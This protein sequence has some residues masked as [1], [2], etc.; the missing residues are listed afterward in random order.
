MPRPRLSDFCHNWCGRVSIIC[1]AALVSVVT[2]AAAEVVK[3]QWRSSEAR[4]DGLIAEWKT[5]TSVTKEVTVGA[6]NDGTWVQLAISASDA[7]TR[8]RLMA[9]GLIVYLDPAGKKNKTFGVRIPP[10]QP[11]RGMG[12]VWTGTGAFGDPVDDPVLSRDAR[13]TITYVEII[14]PEK[15]QAR[16]LDLASDGSGPIE[17]AAGENTGTLLIEVALP[18]RP[19]EL[20]PYSPNISATQKIVGLGLVTPAHAQVGRGRSGGGARGGGGMSGGG[21][22]GRGGGGAGRGGGMGDGPVRLPGKALN[23]W[24]TIE[25]VATEAGR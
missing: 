9:S 24:T 5:L 21:R 4:V 11:G 3:S 22:G 20:H 13:P 2:L 1:C 23:A 16:I 7:A 12:P 6:V 17:V 15:D 25:L 8:Q 18:L 14:G 10:L 19:F